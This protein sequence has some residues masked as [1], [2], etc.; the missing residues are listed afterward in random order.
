MKADAM[1][2]VEATSAVPP[3]DAAVPGTDTRRGLQLFVLSFVALFLEL[4][5]IRWAPSVVRLVAYYANLMLISS[6]LGLGMGAMLGQSRKSLFA[7]FPSLLAVG[8][9]FLWLAQ[10]LTMPGA[11]SEHRF[12]AEAPRVVSYLSLV[13]IFL[14]NAAVFV[15]LGQRIG[16]LFETLPPLGAYSWDLGGSLAGTIGFGLFSLARFSPAVGVG[17]VSLVVACLLPWRRLISAAPLLVIVCVYRSNDPDAIWSPYYNS[18]S[19]R[20]CPTP[21]RPKRRGC[22]SIGRG[23]KYAR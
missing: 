20:P 1:P 5:V 14:T 17:L 23:R 11:A 15:P 18:P 6:F 7:W 3:Q 12:N 16:A 9:A 22:R 8:V 10:G 13:G 21:R 4:T 19:E 2:P